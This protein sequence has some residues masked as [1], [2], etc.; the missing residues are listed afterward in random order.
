VRA[1]IERVD[2]MKMIAESLV[3]DESVLQIRAAAQTYSV[4]LAD[5]HRV[6]VLGAGKAGATMTLGLEEVL[7]DWITDGV[8]AVKA[9][10]TGNA[11]TKVRLVEAGHPV[12]DRNSVHAAREVLR[13]AESADEGTLCIALISGGGS[14][15]LTLPASFEGVQLTLEDIQVT[16]QLLLGAGTPIGEINCVRKHLS[17]ISGGRFCRVVAPATLVAL[18]LSDVVGDDLAS[19]ASGLASPDNGT[20]QEAYQICA[21]DGI[22]D[23]LPKRVREMLLA[24]MRDEIPETPKPGD[25]AF[26]RVHPL[27]IGTNSLALDAARQCA[28][29]LGYNT[30]VLTS[31]LT[32][33]ARE[34][35]RVLAGI[36]ADIAAREVPLRKPACLL[37]GGETT[38]TLRGSGKGGRNQEM[39]LSFLEQIA[40][41]PEAFRGVSF[42]S[43]GTDGNDGPTDAAGAWATPSLAERSNRS[44]I[45]EALADNDSY[46]FF[47]GVGGLLKTGPTN[48]NV[49]DIQVLLVE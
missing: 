10:H 31:R 22:A 34:V 25:P 19:I 6:I 26:E 41:Q 1:A 21:R 42:L 33:E 2:P 14:S 45:S 40:A 30:L 23:K 18:I 24:G 38:V 13:L 47:D 44:A 29:E 36:A 4:D 9:G 39:A 17:G 20:Y 8:V 46:H 15:L 43:V 27:L 16:T 37:A 28:E 32:G 12:P 48:T 35:G 5:F 3:L 49:C 11:S 7:G